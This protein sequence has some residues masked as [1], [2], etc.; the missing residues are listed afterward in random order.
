M[1]NDPSMVELLLAKG[2]PIDSRDS[3]GDTALM[4]AQGNDFVECERVLRAAAE[5]EE[6][7]AEV[8]EVKAEVARATGD[9]VETEAQVE[10]DA[11]VGNEVK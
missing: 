8:K 10:T 6:A 9:Q 11:T 2:F 4:L 7:E 5:A 1:V 3:D